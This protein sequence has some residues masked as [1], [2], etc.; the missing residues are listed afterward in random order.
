MSFFGPLRSDSTTTSVDVPQ[1]LRDN[2]KELIYGYGIESHALEYGGII[3]YV[4]SVYQ[5]L[6]LA[7]YVCQ[8]MNQKSK[9]FSYTVVPYK[10][11]LKK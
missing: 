7:E 11:F 9:D 3:G 2:V 5:S 1:S 6:E 8:Q 10:I 4:N